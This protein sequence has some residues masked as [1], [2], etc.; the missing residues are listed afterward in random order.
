LK[1]KFFDLD[2]L[3]DSDRSLWL[4][5]FRG[6]DFILCRLTP[7]KYHYHHMPVSGVVRDHYE[8]SGGYT[9][10]NPGVVATLVTPYSK[11]KRV[12]T[13]V[14]TNVEGGSQIGLVAMIEV[15]ALMISDITQC[16]SKEG[17]KN[18]QPVEPGLF[19]QQG[20][21]KSLYRPGSS[22]TG[23]FFQAGRVEFADDL[24]RNRQWMPASHSVCIIVD[25]FRCRCVT[26]RL[27]EA[28][29]YYW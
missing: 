17:Y 21:P 11:N 15:A 24:V 23:V 29:F 7:E 27:S 14:D 8:I 1:W 22:T 19:L 2:E 16:Y 4:R 9:S 26:F 12:V 25:A 20:A 3:F 6:G 18:P 10:C 28:A 13:I 5:A